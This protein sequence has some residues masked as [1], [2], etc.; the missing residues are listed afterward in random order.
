MRGVP[1]G[2]RRHATP[3]HDV[4]GSAGGEARQWENIPAG[5]RKGR[6]GGPTE[7]DVGLCHP[8]SSL[9]LIFSILSV[10]GINCHRPRSSLFPLSSSVQIK[11]QS[12]LLSSPPSL[13]LTSHPFFR[14]F[15]S[16]PLLPTSLFHLTSLFPSPI[17][18]SPL[19][20]A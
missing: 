3:L 10:A 18:L 7:V 8:D 9:P 5:E 4:G 6:G 15:S 20:I 13:Q 2:E 12:S 19:S 14:P 1:L 16:L 11:Q 17:R